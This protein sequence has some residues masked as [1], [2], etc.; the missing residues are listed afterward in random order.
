[1]EIALVVFLCLV[2]TAYLIFLLEA[3]VESVGEVRIRKL[4]IIVPFRNERNRILPLLE[5]LVREFSQKDDVQIFFVNDSS[6]DDSV[7][8]IQHFL[9][10]K[11]LHYLLLPNF[12]KG[13]KKA[14]ETASQFCRLTDYILTLDADVTL[15]KGYA[16]TILSVKAGKGLTVLG[17]DYPKPVSTLQC[18]VKLESLFQK[19]MFASNPFG[20]SPSLCSGAH[21]MYSTEFFEHVQPYENNHEIASGD[22]MFFLDNCL[23]S[24]YKIHFDSSAV[25]TEYPAG[26]NSLFK[27]RRRWLSKTAKLSSKYYFRFA[28]MFMLLLLVPVILLWFYPVY[29][30]LFWAVR[31]VFELLFLMKCKA[32]A[33]KLAMTLPLFWLFQ[34]SMPLL[35]IFGRRRDEQTW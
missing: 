5:D 12:G 10:D 16:E 3:G 20:N 11:D 24:G 31:A 19:P 23:R 34:Y 6:D 2:L 33:P 32:F 18:L 13:K 35:Y 25:I 21:L 27:Q 1:M 30:Y 14:L 4:K 22:D 17:I 15:P 28:F 7:E 9:E 29:A 8:C 26:I